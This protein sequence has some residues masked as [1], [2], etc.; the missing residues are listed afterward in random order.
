MLV[1]H[2]SQPFVYRPSNGHRQ[3]INPLTS[4]RRPPVLDRQTERKAS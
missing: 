2:L 1:H 4:N 3:M